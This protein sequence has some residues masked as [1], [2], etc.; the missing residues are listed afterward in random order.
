MTGGMTNLILNLIKSVKDENIH[1]DFLTSSISEEYSKVISSRNGKVFEI[2]RRT[3][4]LFSYIKTLMR[5]IKNENYDAVHIHA[6]SHT[7]ILELIAAK[8]AGCP[9]RIVHAHS[10]KCNNLFLHKILSPIFNRLCTHRFACGLEAGKFMHG[11][12][13]FTVIKNGIHLDNFKFNESNVND[14]RK[15]HNVE[16]KVIVG[17]VANFI[18]VKNHTFL[19][20]VFADLCKEKDTYVLMLLGTGALMES[21]KEKVDNLGLN[22]KV[23]FIGSTPEVPKY[24]S[25]FDITVLPSLYEGVPL[26]L[27]EAQS[28]GL[29]CIASTNVPDEVNITGNIEFLPIDTGTSV[30]VERLKNIDLTSDR[31]SASNEAI[32]KITAAGYDINEQAFKL[33]SYYNSLSKQPN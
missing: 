14:I 24:L 26:S 21:I 18:E 27:I 31:E 33:E 5:L 29:K 15:K 9:V 17:H 32:K 13:N 30:W 23:L 1:I 11:K 19:I 6:N 28:N 4:H 8:R 16:N 3:K 12:N 20:D 7:A 10:T 2:N 25:A 22:D